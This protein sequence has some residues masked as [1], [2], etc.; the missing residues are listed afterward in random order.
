VLGCW[1]V[2]AGR[3]VCTLATAT[4]TTFAATFAVCARFA[5]LARLLAF[6]GSTVAV[7]GSAVTFCT[8]RSVTF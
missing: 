4:A 2:G 6:T 5:G 1:H 8:G 7:A 3:A